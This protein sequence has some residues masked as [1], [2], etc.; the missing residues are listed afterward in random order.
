MSGYLPINGGGAGG[1]LLI[2]DSA[3][4]PFATTEARD[5]WAKLNL[6]DLIKDTTAVNVTGASWFVWRGETNPETYNPSLWVNGDEL[7]KGQTG[8]KG[9]AGQKGDTGPSGKSVSLLQDGVETIP[10]MS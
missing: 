9:N 2:P 1:G 8:A 6:S 3:A 4:I 10:S 5:T 7:V